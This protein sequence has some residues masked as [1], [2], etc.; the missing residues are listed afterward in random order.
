MKRSSA[1]ALD[2]AR[3]E[4]DE[5]GR[6]IGMAALVSMA[7]E[8]VDMTP[9]WDRLMER[10][11]KQGSDCAAA[12][13]D[14]ATILQSRGSTEAALQVLRGAVE[15]RRDFSI[16]HGNGK[17]PRLLAFVTPGDFMANTPLDFLLVHSNCILN[18]Y[19]V[20]AEMTELTDLPAHDVA[21]MAIGE[22]T[23][24]APVL[25]RMRQLLA[26]FPGPVMNN[27]PELISRLTRDGVSSMLANEPSILSPK[28]FRISREEA[29]D[30]A[31]SRRA[32]DDL[33]PGLS[34]PI[35]VRPIGTHAGNG[36]KLIE[37]LSDLMEWL[38]RDTASE[39]YIAPF[40]DFRGP[41]DL[42][43]KQRIV[44]INGKAYAS[45]MALSEHWIV[46]YLSAGMAKNAAKRAVEQEWMENFDTDFAVRHSASFEALYRHV[47]LDYF[48]I[49]CAELPDGRL[50]V[51]EL[52]VAMFV[53]SMDDAVVFP[54]KHVAM[55]KLFDSF[56]EAVGEAA[57]NGTVSRA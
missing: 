45:H 19:H 6:V 16:V 1:L 57:V 31:L 12:M 24:S 41:D 49:D 56:V 42:Y 5:S 11:M 9:L 53:H 43:N 22:S 35:I 15:L 39:I 4:I 28:T 10:A 3:H 7:Y 25:E 36:M 54:Y 29:L 23:E 27:K 38:D 51:F 33:A 44:F 21:F 14:L 47:G 30:I 2:A 37:K 40:I 50:L 20:D 17:G 26:E 18:L 52:D 32:V 13:F 8:Q 46:H 55:R 34:L 48:G